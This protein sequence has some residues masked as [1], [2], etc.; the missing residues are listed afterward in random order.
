MK[1]Y[2]VDS[3]VCSLQD[4]QYILY[5]SIFSISVMNLLTFEDLAFCYRYLKS[6]KISSFFCIQDPIKKITLQLLFSKSW[7]IQRGR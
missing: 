5:I 6:L 1:P 7:E 3:S 2:G 4:E